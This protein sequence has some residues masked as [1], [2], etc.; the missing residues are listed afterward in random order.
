MVL[1]PTKGF[2]DYMVLFSYT[3]WIEYIALLLNLCSLAV[4]LVKC[5]LLP[6]TRQT[7]VGIQLIH[8]H[9]YV[10]YEYSYQTFSLL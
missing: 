4:M 5:H 9:V 6:H 8:V 7:G 1:L 2:H 10:P 3:L